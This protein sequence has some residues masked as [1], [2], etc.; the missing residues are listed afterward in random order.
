MYDFIQQQL[1]AASQKKTYGI[2]TAAASTWCKQFLRLLTIRFKL[3]FYEKTFTAFHPNGPSL[4]Y[5]CSK[6][7]SQQKDKLLYLCLSA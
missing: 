4:F 2:S 3:L 7:C 5:I 6:S 1:F